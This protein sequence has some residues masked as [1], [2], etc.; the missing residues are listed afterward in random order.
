MQIL[1]LVNIYAI[2]YNTHQLFATFYCSVYILQSS[3]GVFK[4]LCRP[5]CT[6]NMAPVIL[7][8]VQQPARILKVIKLSGY[9]L[10]IDNN[11]KKFKTRK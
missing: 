4:Y 5:Q 2:K 8:R 1:L 3:V 7:T 9:Y 10:H 11:L 6:V